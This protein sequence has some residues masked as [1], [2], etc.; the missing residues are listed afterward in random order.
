MTMKSSDKQATAELMAALVEVAI[1][2]GRRGI[3][4]DAYLPGWRSSAYH[5]CCSPPSS[6]G[7]STAATAGLNSQL[8]P[9]WPPAFLVGP[10]T[11]YR[12][13]RAGVLF[14]LTAPGR[15]WRPKR[16]ILLRCSTPRRRRRRIKVRGWRVIPGAEG[17]VA[18]LSAG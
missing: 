13:P 6:D 10:S 4:D 2:H 18:A 9:R 15:Y 16:S 17:C 1:A 12:R 7:L 3:G 8:A 14:A 5:P 11:A